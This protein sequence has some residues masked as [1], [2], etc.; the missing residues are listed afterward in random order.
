[1]FVPGLL[2]A[3]IGLFAGGVGFVAIPGLVT[4]AKIYRTGVALLRRETRAA[5]FRARE[6]AAWALWLNG[7]VFVAS[8]F[9]VP[10]AFAHAALARSLAFI[11]GYGALSMLQALLMLRCAHVWEDALF[12]L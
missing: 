7:I 9:F 11:D 5:A 10:Q 12:M 1:M 2:L 3:L 8:L 6:A 4:A